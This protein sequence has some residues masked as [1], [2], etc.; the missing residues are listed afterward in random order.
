MLA[1][2]EL[3]AN[4]NDLGGSVSAISCSAVTV[5][6]ARDYQLRSRTRNAVV[7]SLEHLDTDDF[8]IFAHEATTVPRHGF[9]PRSR[10]TGLIR[11]GLL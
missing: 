5:T 10:R 2:S 11:A 1:Y 7:G 3:T 9:C 8:A 4:K 6:D